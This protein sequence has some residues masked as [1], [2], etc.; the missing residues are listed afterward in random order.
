MMDGVEENVTVEFNSVNIFNLK[1][2]SLPTKQHYLLYE[3]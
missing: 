2:V 1:R 3:S